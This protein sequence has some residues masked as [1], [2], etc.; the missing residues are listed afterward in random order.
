LVGPPSLRFGAPQANL[1]NAIVG[2]RV[3]LRVGSVY[4]DHGCLGVATI[5]GRLAPSAPRR[6]AVAPRAWPRSAS[7]PRG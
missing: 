1:A 4:H 6:P 5:V 3:Q 2:Y 7:S